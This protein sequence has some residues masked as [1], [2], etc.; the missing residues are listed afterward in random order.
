MP[1]K[2]FAYNEYLSG[3]FDPVDE[4]SILKER[5]QLSKKLWLYPGGFANPGFKSSADSNKHPRRPDEARVI[6]LR[7][8][9]ISFRFLST[10]HIYHLLGIA[11]FIATL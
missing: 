9:T 4:F 3:M 8:V 6:E 2:R 10:C 5:I 7:E 11:C 1:G